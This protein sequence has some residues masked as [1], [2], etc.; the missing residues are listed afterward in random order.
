M[1]DSKESIDPLK[2]VHEIRRVVHE[3]ERTT[4]AMRTLGMNDGADDLVYIQKTIDYLSKE[5]AAGI[6]RE[7]HELL[8]DGQRRTGEL[9]VAVL[10]SCTAQNEGH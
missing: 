9:L 6:C 1:N 2:A 5:A 3:L 10:D 4:N 7:T 8:M